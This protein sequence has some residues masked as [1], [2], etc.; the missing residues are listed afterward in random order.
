MANDK[1]ASFFPNLQIV[2]GVA[3]LLVVVNHIYAKEVFFPSI[4]T[5]PFE[6]WFANFGVTGLTLF[7]CLSGFLITSILLKE[8]Q[9][10]N[11]IQIRSFYIRRILRI[12][13]LYFC[14]IILGQFILP[15][16]IDSNFEGGN[17]Q[18]CFTLKSL[19]YLAFLPNYV[20]FIFQPHNPFIDVTWSIGVEE[21]FYL[22]WP[23]FIK[24]IKS[25]LGICIILIILQIIAEFTTTPL[26]AIKDSNLFYF[27]LNKLIKITEWSKAGYFALG[28]ISAII[29]NRNLHIKNSIIIRLV[30]YSPL[31]F[32]IA[33]ILNM[34]YFFKGQF[35][36]L[37]TAYIF[38]Q[39]KL[40]QQTNMANN[41]L[42][43]FF[44]WLGTISYS[45]YLWHCFVIVLVYKGFSS[46]GNSH[47]ATFTPLLYFIII[48]LTVGISA[49]SYQ[50]I[51]KPFLRLKDRLNK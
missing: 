14:L 31:L 6:H 19:L 5:L 3:A 29:Y 17:I 24:R 16:L 8:K 48:M 28:A 32:A 21:Q 26:N 7:F 18:S 38:L 51:E 13:P 11:N 2:R 42:H 37:A 46:I 41:I 35:L 34:L 40:L 43:R 12:W 45:M 33:F 50:L 49:L 1:A 27:L 10:T 9:H 23:H 30:K 25:V 4:T 44:Q 36:L 15:F 47:T 39:I 22:F 20:F